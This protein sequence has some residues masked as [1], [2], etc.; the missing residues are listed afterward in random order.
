MSL[1]RIANWLN[2]GGIVCAAVILLSFVVLPVE[3]TH[4][5]YLSVCLILGVA[6]MQVSSLSPSQDPVGEGC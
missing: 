3:K 5:H 2:V 6:M 4:R 1:T